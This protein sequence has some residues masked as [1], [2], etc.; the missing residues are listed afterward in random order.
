MRF[1][2]FFKN[3]LLFTIANDYSFDF[4]RKTRFGKNIA[5]IFLQIYD[6]TE[7]EHFNVVYFNES[8]VKININYELHNIREES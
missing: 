5:F 4:K 6:L 2:L 8:F 1:P 7:N 3:I